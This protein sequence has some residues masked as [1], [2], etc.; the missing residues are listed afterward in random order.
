MCVCESS[1]FFLNRIHGFIYAA[2]VEMYG[3]F[4]FSP[5][6]PYRRNKV[7]STARGE[8][9]FRWFSFPFFFYVYVWYLILCVCVCLTVTTPAFTLMIRRR[10]KRKKIARTHILSE[11]KLP[12]FRI[13]PF[14]F[15]IVFALVLYRC[16]LYTL[17]CFACE[18]AS[19]CVF[20]C[21]H[22][23]RRRRRGKKLSLLARYSEEMKITCASVWLIKILYI[24][25]HLSSGEWT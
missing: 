10:K 22:R 11:I 1:S 12:N 8:T 25:C 14:V 15:M 19:I 7:I 21:T 5:C 3:F 20:L 4:H 23:I 16:A 17:E 18:L 9:A 13:S 2:I 24:F 6:Q